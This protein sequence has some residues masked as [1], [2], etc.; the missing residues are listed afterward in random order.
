MDGEEKSTTVQSSVSV[1]GDVIVE[2]TMLVVSYFAPDGTQRYAWKSA[3]E[4][5]LAQGLGLLEIVKAHM[6]AEVA[7]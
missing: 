4:F 2:G 7:G 3:G 5:S 6:M 1:P